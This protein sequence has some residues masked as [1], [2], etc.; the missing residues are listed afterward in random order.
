MVS[1]SLTT[2]HTNKPNAKETDM[3]TSF[4]RR[5]AAAGLALALGAT[6]AFADPA[7]IAVGQEGRGYEAFGKQMVQRLGDRLPSEIVNYEGSDDI[8][9]AVCDGDADMGIMQI[10]AIY[11]RSLEGCNLRVVGTYGTEYAYLLFPPDG[12][13]DLGDLGENKKILVDTIGSGTD[14]FWHTAVSIETGEHGN[15]SSWSK[16]TPVNDPIFIAQTLADMG[17]IDAALM[18][19]TPTS[20]ELKELIDAGWTLGKLKDKDIDDQQFN[21]SSL[22][23][24]EDA[25]VAG[26]G[27][28]FSGNDSN[29]SYAIRSFV[30]ISE[31]LMKDRRAFADVA[32]AVKTLSAATN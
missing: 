24:R 5:I 18:V 22:Y 20:T 23:P 15:K 9:R 26:T 29:K 12:G 3:N 10:D 16:T 21:G 11:A 13:S 31:E 1:E 4:I 30:V 14:L 2:R 25:E 7:I 8:S 32:R 28:F 6:A 17:E 19:T 27:G